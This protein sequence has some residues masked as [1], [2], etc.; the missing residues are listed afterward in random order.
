MSPDADIVVHTEPCADHGE[1]IIERIRMVVS[2]NSLDAH[3]IMVQDT[4]GKMCVDLHLEVDDDLSLH[5]AHDRAN[6]IEREVRA[7]I[8]GIS[9]VE[10]H[11]EPRTVE[12]GFYLDVTAQETLLTEKIRETA[13]RIVGSPCCH[14]VRLRRKGDILIASLHCTFEDEV[15]ITQAHNMAT[16]IE[17]RLQVEIPLLERVLVHAEPERG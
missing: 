10:I 11:M 3:N 15:S 5:E 4:A 1:S 6:R 2:R 13:D 17:A 9:H 8:A 14:E 16:H 7:E 12:M